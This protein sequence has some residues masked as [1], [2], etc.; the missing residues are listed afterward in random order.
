M[1]INYM[2]YRSVSKSYI[3]SF[4]DIKF[5]DDRHFFDITF[6]TIYK[7]VPGF[8]LNTNYVYICLVCDFYSRGVNR[9]IS[10]KFYSWFVWTK[11]FYISVTVKYVK[12][13][14]T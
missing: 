10:L 4:A 13:K 9:S 14:K 5:D 3:F 7:Y 12:R 6:K 2:F 1:V 11:H 8:F